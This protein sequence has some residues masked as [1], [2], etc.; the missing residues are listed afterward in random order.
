M[1]AEGFRHAVETYGIRC[2]VNL[3]NEDEKDRDLVRSWWDGRKVT[4][5]EFCKELGVKYIQLAPDL[6]PRTSRPGTRPKVIEEMLRVYDDPGN[7]PILIHCKAGLHRTGILS[8]IYRMEYEGWT[9]DQAYRE[10]GLHGF[11]KECHEANDYVREYVLE[12]Q[13]GLRQ[14]GQNRS[15]APPA[16]VP[17]SLEN[18]E[19]KLLGKPKEA[20]PCSP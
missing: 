1:T 4:E 17:I 6:V 13:P 12:Y 8:A 16:T 2:V 15:L 9:P 10:L 5:A 18:G 7:Y 14:L 19:S 20:N 3:Q 11:G